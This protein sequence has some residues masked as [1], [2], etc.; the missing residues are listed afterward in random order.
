MNKY[1]KQYKPSI[2]EYTLLFFIFIISLIGSFYY[3]INKIYNCILNHTENLPYYK[4]QNKV[5]I[6]SVDP[7][8]LKNIETYSSIVN[9]LIK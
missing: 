7:L 5:L 4:Q 2:N 6:S 1:I 8:N 9:N 3:N